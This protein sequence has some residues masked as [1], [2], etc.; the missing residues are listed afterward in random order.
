[1]ITVKLLGGLGNQMFQAAY[2]MALTGK[3]YEVQFDRSSLIEGT[4]R[5]YSLG[6]F[7]PLREGTGTGPAVYENGMAFDPANLE[8]LAPCTMV[9]YWQSEKYFKDMAK[10]IHWLFNFNKAALFNSSNGSSE[11]RKDIY[12]SDSIALHVRR[13]D[14]VKLQHFHGMPTVDY[15]R[16]A[17][18]YIRR[19]RYDTKVFVFSDD[20]QWCEENFPRDFTFVRGTDK[21]EDLRL[22]SECKHAVIA[23]SSFSWWGAWLQQKLGGIIVAPKQWFADP[24]MNDV[25]I[26]PARWVKM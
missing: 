4:H 14:Y 15:Y 7:W 10:E 18:A 13:Q 1:M 9:G 8:P 12:R 5:E 17:V 11:I 24:N 21:Y 16:E 2:G 26:V 19:R 20:I 22:M 25:D 6:H 23:N 3:G